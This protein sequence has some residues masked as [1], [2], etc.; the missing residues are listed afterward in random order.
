MTVEHACYRHVPTSVGE[1][2]HTPFEALIPDIANGVRAAIATLLPFYFASSLGRPELAWTALG[3]WLGTLA[4]PGGSRIARTKSL[5]L[6]VSLGAL[7]LMLAELASENIALATLAF[8]GAAFLGSLFR[9]LGAASA[10]LGTMLAIIVA[11]GSASRSPSPLRDAALFTLGAA[12]ATALAAVVWPIWTHLPVR[13]AVGAVFEQL[14]AYA[15]DI[16]SSIDEDVPNGGQRWVTLAR[17]HRR[18]IRDS[19]EA[20]RKMALAVRARRPGESNVG[21]NVRT[22]L[23]LAEAQFPLL[24]ALAEG[25]ESDTRERRQHGR[26]TLEVVRRRYRAIH[27]TLIRTVITSRRPR[28]TSPVKRAEALDVVGRRLLDGSDLAANISRAIDARHG[29]AEPIVAAN[30]PGR[31]RESVESLHSGIRALRD[32]L[33]PA[34]P[35]FRHALRV[36]GAAGVASL[37]GQR[38][39]PAHTTW[40]TITTIAVLQPYPGTT[41]QR[42]AERVV[43]TVLGSVVAVAITM[44]IHGPPALLLVMFPLCVAA[45]ATRPRS[46]RLFT[47]FLTPI[48][49]LLA[50]KHPGD[51]WT[52]AARSGDAALGGAI[53]LVAA[54]FVFPSWE[55]T[56][57]SDALDDMLGK[58]LAYA[59]AV[60]S[61]VARPTSE[62]V[63]EIEAARRAC[64]IALSEAEASLE[65]LLAEPLRDNEASASDAMQLVTFARRLAGA[66]TAL[67]INVHQAPSSTQDAVVLATA[68]GSEH[69]D[70]YVNEVLSAARAFA[71]THR[72]AALPPPPRS[73]S[74]TEPRL[75]IIV[76]RVVAQTALIASV[77][78]EPPREA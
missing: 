17:S 18:R 14:A 10:S 52:A 61:S 63:V 58:T 4:D 23:G 78:G 40:V 36:A 48:F 19:I 28:P 49:V 42:A 67:E 7:A 15:A 11:I 44:T 2:S 57:L 13:R 59:T 55:Q 1:S 66:V 76:G 69:V 70:T 5:A 20:A 47:F 33:S 34:S 72:T 29:A 9:V 8:A 35:H 39:S 74:S 31:L 53:A 68:L 51:W 43:G 71:K 75:A 45:V 73:L 22:L 24:I 32:A 16:E 65:R 38:V 6:F 12:W 37:V 21:A 77:V 41:W 62:V 56:R 26:R 60:L 50:E 30:R 64:G 54:L 3:G 27:H 25:I 46:Y